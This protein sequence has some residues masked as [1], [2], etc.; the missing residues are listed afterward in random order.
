MVKMKNVCND[1]LADNPKLIKAA[2]L[3]AEKHLLPS[4]LTPTLK[5]TKGKTLSSEFQ[6]LTKESRHFSAFK[7]IGAVAE[8][9]DDEDLA[10][11]PPPP[12]SPW[13]TPKRCAKTPSETP[14]P[15]HSSSEERENAAAWQ[16]LFHELPFASPTVSTLGAT[17]QEKAES[18]AQNEWL[19]AAPKQSKRYALSTILIVSS[20]CNRP[21]CPIVKASR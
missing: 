4:N 9:K 6:K 17:P 2:K 1:R 7:G 13:K 15:A 21:E 10:T 12:S 16:K 20:M 8:G 14:L 19:P 11:S 5:T 3:E 18:V